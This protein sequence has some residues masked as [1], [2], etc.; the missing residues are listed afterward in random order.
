MRWPSGR[1]SI[2][3]GPIADGDIYWHLAAGDEIWRRGALLR[4][5]PFTVSAAGRAWV[6]VHWLFQV[7]VALIHRAFGFGGLAAA[8]AVLVA[9][10][11]ALGTRTAER[12]GGRRRAISAPRRCWGCCSS[13]GTS[14]RCDPSSR[15]CFSSPLPRRPR[16][17]SPSDASTPAR[18]ALFVLPA[19]QAIWVNCQ[20]L[21]PLGS[22]LVAAYLLAMS[23]R[24][25]APARRRRHAVAL[26]PLGDRARGLPARLVRDART[27][28]TLF[29]CPCAS[30]LASSRR[31][32]RVQHSLAE[33]ISP[34]VLARTSPE[35]ASHLGWVLAAMGAAMLLV[36]PRL[37]AAHAFV[38]FGFTALALMANR[39]VILL[40]WVLAPIGAIA[41]APYAVRRWSASHASGSARRSAPSWAGSVTLAAVLAAELGLA[42]VALAREP[43]IGAPTP[44]HFPTESARLLARIGARGPV[45]APDQ[46]GGSWP[47]RCR[48]CAPIS[49]PASC[50]TRPGEYEDYLALFDEPARFDALDARERFR[51]VVLTTAYPDR[52]L[53]LVA[54]LVASPAW[55]VLY[56]DGSEVLFARE[57]RALDLG[58]CATVD[59]TAAALDARFVSR[60][61][62]ALAPRRLNLAGC[63]SSSASPGPP[64]VCSRPSPRAA[65]ELRAR[66]HFAAGELGAAESLACVSARAS[67]RRPKLDAPG[68]RLPSPAAFPRTRV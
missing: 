16:T 35:M 44:F 55:K 23:S 49:I 2:A 53:G 60:P 64:S 65:A 13:P 62:G 38:L 22:A 7:A 3:L 31:G 66:G 46:H 5:D 39:N 27:V 15:R 59:A 6:D 51:Y 68:G 41:L 40:Y 21:A 42:G 12:A 26:S 17:A 37:V 1:R 10:G 57:G 4:T 11:A 52:Y 34:F 67:R 20:G 48:G 8:K 14:C 54:H 32:Q 28:S 25:L 18:R 63:S 19:L 58:D 30:S 24:R 33:N 61:R 50:S 9:A 29:G 43:P 45:F 36:R 47:S 56:T